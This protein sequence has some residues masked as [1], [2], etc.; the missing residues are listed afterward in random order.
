MHFH[1]LVNLVFERHMQWTAARS[2]H[3][4]PPT[5]RAVLGTPSL[6]KT[7]EYKALRYHKQHLKYL[8]APYQT[9]ARSPSKITCNTTSASPLVVMIDLPS[10]ESLIGLFQSR[11]SVEYY[12]HS[13]SKSCGQ[14]HTGCYDRSILVFGAF[15]FVC[16]ESHGVLRRVD[17]RWM[18]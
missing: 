16:A 8:G 3:P 7:V 1:W 4:L 5:G 10:R 6:R 9:R 2:P 17:L 11:L 13:G 15:V 18:A 14:K 12:N